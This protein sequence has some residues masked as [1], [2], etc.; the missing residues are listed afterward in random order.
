MLDMNK[1][2]GEKEELYSMLSHPSTTLE[3]L[4][5]YQTKLSCKAA[6]IL[7]TTLQQNRTLKILS[8]EHNDITNDSCTCIANTIKLNSSLIKLWMRFNPITAE[9]IRPILLALK[10][11]NTLQRLRLPDY[12]D[13]VKR[14]IKLVEEETNKRRASHGSRVKLLTDFEPQ[15]EHLY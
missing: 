15:I 11:N 10:C 7:F 6:N 2:I 1:T 5:M 9:G 13:D 12:P 4:S 14:D 3:T 8:I